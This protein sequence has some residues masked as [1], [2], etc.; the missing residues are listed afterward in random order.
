[1]HAT[2]SGGD[3]MVPL[4]LEEIDGL[5]AAL[6][7]EVE[8]RAALERQLALA[9]DRSPPPTPVFAAARPPPADSQPPPPPLAPAVSPST[10]GQDGA[11][12]GA[13]PTFK[14]AESVTGPAAAAEAQLQE[15][16][17]QFAAARSALRAAVPAL[18]TAAAEL[19][20]SPSSVRFL[21]VSVALAWSDRHAGAVCREA[22]GR[23]TAAARAE[24]A[25][26]SAVGQL[27]P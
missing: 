23:A 10:P 17:R 7:G 9:E 8:L 26:A 16:L 21:S 14:L 4:L 19:L 22:A 27:G 11:A 6:Q 25:A 20:S 13:S 24:C 3:G 1:M 2:V 5:R 12:Y 18:T 15:E